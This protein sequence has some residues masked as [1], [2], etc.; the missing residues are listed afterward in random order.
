[1]IKAILFDF[2]YTL[3]DREKYAYACYRDILRENTSI[4]D[5]VEF[6]AVLQD[7]MIWDQKGD[8][9]KKYIKEKLNE[10]YDIRLPYND[11]NTYWDSRLWQY[12]EMYP[13]SEPTLKELEKRYKLGIITNGPSEGQRNK[14]RKSGAD[15][16]FAESAVVISGECGMKKPDPEIFRYAC[17]KLN[18]LTEESVYVGDLYQKDILGARRAGLETVWICSGRGIC[19]TD[20]KIIHRISELVDLY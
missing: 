19:G 12:C 1:M 7:C 17:G 16:Y 3:G 10:V 9:N 15:K 5:P 20:Q 18:V 11:F 8:V 14:L 13:D 4:K 2:D 6:E